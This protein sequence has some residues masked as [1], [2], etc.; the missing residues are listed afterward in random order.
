MGSRAVVEKAYLQEAREL[1]AGAQGRVY[2]AM[3]KM[4]VGRG[5]RTSLAEVLMGVLVQRHGVGVDVRVL[6]SLGKKGRGVYG[7]NIVAARWLGERGVP[8]RGLERGRTCHAKVV[9][10]DRVGALVGSHNWA[11]TSL[12]RNFEVSVLVDE[13]VVIGQLAAMFERRWRSGVVFGE[14]T[15]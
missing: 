6:L 5:L 7:A 10:A 11:D 8:V 2:V 1:I 14:E 9:I 13:E 15:W 4:Q 3:Y 12:K